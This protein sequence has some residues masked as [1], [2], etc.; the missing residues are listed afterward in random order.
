V[1]SHS[2]PGQVIRQIQTGTDKTVID[3]KRKVQEFFLAPNLSSAGA[4]DVWKKIPYFIPVHSYSRLG[5]FGGDKEGK[6][7]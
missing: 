5:S 3:I 1:C 6:K 4:V 7:I 2:I